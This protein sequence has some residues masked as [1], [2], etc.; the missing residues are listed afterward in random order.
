MSVRSQQQH[1]QQHQHQHSSSYLVSNCKLW[2]HDVAELHMWQWRTRLNML[3]TTHI[4][5]REMQFFSFCFVVGCDDATGVGAILLLFKGFRRCTSAFSSSFAVAAISGCTADRDK[6]DASA[7]GDVSPI[8]DDGDV[9]EVE[10]EW[11]FLL[12][13]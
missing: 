13:F 8:R 5:S 10:P 11:L 7:T 4:I 12:L 9:Y 1:Q 6:N 3:Q 2:K